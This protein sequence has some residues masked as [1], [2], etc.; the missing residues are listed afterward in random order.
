MFA[1]QGHE[2]DAPEVLLVEAV[3]GPARHSDQ[4]LVAFPFAKR[5]HQPPARRELA[6]QHVR[7]LR[8][9]RGDEDRVERR[10]FGPAPRAVSGAHLHP[11]E[12]ERLQP[13]ACGVRQFG[14][15]LDGADAIGDEARYGG[16][17]ARARTDLEHPVV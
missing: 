14:V 5:H 13:L 15:A 17:V 9:G 3:I 10:S 7:D 4:P 12:A 2:G 11:I 6:Q 16:G 8:T 1:D